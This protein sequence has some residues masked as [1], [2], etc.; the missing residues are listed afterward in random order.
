MKK[1][2]LKKLFKNTFMLYLL[3]GSKFIFPLITFPYLTRILQNEKYG[4]MIF[5]A[6]FISYFILFVDFGFLQS[7]TKK[8]AENKNNKDELS[9]IIYDTTFSKVILCI[10]GILIL[11]LIILFSDYLK[12]KELY[13]I[14]SYLV[15]VMTSFNIDYYFRGIEEMTGITR[16]TIFSRLIYTTLI[17]LIVNSP[18]DILFIPIISAIGEFII[19][20]FS[21]ISLYKNNGFNIVKP[22]IHRLVNSLKD[23]S[24]FFISRI[25]T[26]AYSST[27]IIVL[28]IV[29]SESELSLYGVAGG[30][31]INI[32]SLFFPISD[33]LYPY[34]IVKKD[35]DLIKK[36]LLVLM[37]LIIIGSGILFFLTPF[38]INV[39]A[40]SNYLG[41]IVI[42][43]LMIPLI[44]I[45]LPLYIL[46]YP[47][48]G[49]MNKMK[50]ANLS[51]IYASLFHLS[52]LTIL[53]VLNNI[54]FT[55]VI[56]LT[57][58]SESF[59]LL[60]RFIKVKGGLKENENSN[61]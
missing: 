47:V 52:I 50:E 11:V 13:I 48:L 33:S 45:T 60:Y 2:N 58:F 55:T 8:I 51:V 16:R 24:I 5:A 30:I 41:S 6:A 4:L 25:A 34:M 53:F 43:R 54:N 3:Q 29:Y 57:F 27:N 18:N 44:I 23:S 20:L 15:V 49:A 9:K 17:F 39:L 40:G 19:I 7:A 10:L 28:A 59:I 26:T 56:I 46:G 22:N 12:G 14:L 31:I 42:F 32:R 21:W 38:I 1:D 36:I 35:Y 37:P 61:N